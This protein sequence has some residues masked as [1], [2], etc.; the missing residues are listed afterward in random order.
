MSHNLSLNDNQPIIVKKKKKGE[1][2]HHGGAW[3]VAYAD[4]VTAMMALFIVLWVLGQ[5]EEV[6]QAVASYFQNPTS[7]SIGVGS[8]VLINGNPAVDKKAA[9]VIT[10][11][12]EKQ[13]L[14]QMGNELLDQIKEDNEF[15]NILDQVKIEF[16]D[17]GM[18]I[19]LME[20]QHEAFFE[21]GTA[22]LNE[23]AFELLKT[24]GKKLSALDNKL[25]IE[26]HTDARPYQNDGTGYTN[27]ELSSDRANSARR[28][29]VIGGV[30][31]NQVEEIRGYADKKLRN[32]ANPFDIFNRRV[33]IIVKY[34]G[35]K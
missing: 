3:K 14:T 6:K 2:G 21:V 8:G 16:I 7:V 24:I 19:E 33:S 29:L 26:G 25:I 9:E 5:S 4:F 20:S 10:R 28:V 11:E 23:K 22:K 35:E 30:K 12:V 31:E 13:K 17:E 18:Q 34:T 27:F 32:P 1:G 15:N